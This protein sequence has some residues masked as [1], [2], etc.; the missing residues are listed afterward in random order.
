MKKKWMTTA[1]ALL[2]TGVIGTVIPYATTTADAKASVAE[3]SN[4]DLR[5]SFVFSEDGQ[6]VTIKDSKLGD[7]KA[8]VKDLSEKLGIKEDDLNLSSHIIEMQPNTT[9]S[10]IIVK[11]TSFKGEVKE[12]ET[13]DNDVLMLFGLHKVTK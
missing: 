9:G 6:G 7:F 5:I 1:S 2:L 8:T 11:E 10:K 4:L 3:Q 12:Y 13:S